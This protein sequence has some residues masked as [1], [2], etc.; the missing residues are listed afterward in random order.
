MKRMKQITIEDFIQKIEAEFPDMPQGKLTPET[1][2]RDSMDWDSVNALM[3][4][5]LVNIEYDVTLIADE[6]INANTIQD[7]F[8]VVKRKV[9]EKEA[10][11]VKGDLKPDLTEEES[12]AAF[13]ALKEEVAK[14]EE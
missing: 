8:N 12:R 3:F 5:V 10:A 2:F 14:K 11:I 6:F 7:V 1:N 9:E 13:G 4:V